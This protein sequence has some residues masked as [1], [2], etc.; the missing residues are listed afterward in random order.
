[1]ICR[2]VAPSGVIVPNWTSWSSVSLSFLNL[3]MVSAG[4]VDGERRR[5]D[6]DARAVGQARVADRARFVDAAADLA[7]DAL[8]D[9]E[10]LAVVAEA[11]VRLLHLA[12]HFDEDPAGAVDHDVG[13]V[14]ARQQ[15]LER[16]VAEHVVADVL[17]QL[18][19]LG[20][21]HHHVLHRDDVVDDVAD[22]LARLVDVHL[23]QL[24]QVDRVDQRAEDL[25]LQVVVLVRLA[26]LRLHRRDRRGHAARR[27]RRRGAAAAP[28]PARRPDA[29]RGFG[30]GR[31]AA[32]SA[33]LRFPNICFPSCLS[34][35]C[36][37]LGFVFG[38]D[39]SLSKQRTEIEAA[40]ARLLQLL[41]AGD[42]L[43]DVGEDIGDGRLGG[44]FGDHLAV[45]RRP[46]RRAADR[47][48]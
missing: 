10:E 29:R 44:G 9:V 25:R 43:R 45:V 32:N 2:I 41:A 16:A 38:L 19:L 18:L 6:V 12:V 11:D 8:A 5:D 30:S 22:F 35:P 27:L 13:D 39:F 17:E 3:R 21:R 26:R 28:A 24:R 37:A 46:C 14:V 1:M 23:G 20:D 4:A 40:P 48:G 7:D 47:T 15:R 31:S 42:D 33:A 36:L 34:S